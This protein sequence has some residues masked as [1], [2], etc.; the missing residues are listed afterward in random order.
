MM[1][2]CFVGKVNFLNQ[3]EREL[4]LTLQRYMLIFVYY[5]VNN[6]NKIIP[7]KFRMIEV[8]TTTAMQLIVVSTTMK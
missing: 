8:I 5:C 3:W 6:N 1:C 7:N 2:V 4:M